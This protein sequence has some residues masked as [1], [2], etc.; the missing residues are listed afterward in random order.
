MRI[1]LQCSAELDA[2]RWSC[3]E[4]GWQ[5]AYEDNFAILSPDLLA[6]MPDYPLDAHDRCIAFEASSFWFICRNRLIIYCL[7]RYFPNIGNLLE[8]GC[9][10]GFVLSG[11]SRAFPAVKVFGAEAYPSALKY[12]LKRNKNGEFAQMNAY[13]LP[14]EE[15]FSVVGAFDVL[16]H[17]DDDAAALK[18]M[19]RATK[20]GGGIILTVPQH[21]W[22]WSGLDAKAGHKRRYTRRELKDKVQAAGFQVLC[23]TSFITTLL[24][25]MIMSRL[26]KRVKRPQEASAVQCELNLPEKLNNLLKMACLADHWLI[27]KGFELPA[28]G[29]LLCVAKKGSD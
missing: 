13:R 11:I 17:L 26:K 20:D 9:G 19:Y 6:G 18:E 12:A 23:M 25:L 5:P 27:R 28:G 8:I 3:P 2:G 21:P 1:C 10:T 15:E 24:P 4:C 22:L 29:S 7:E 14:F 16:E